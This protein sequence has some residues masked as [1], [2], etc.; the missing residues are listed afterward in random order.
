MGGKGGRCCLE[1]TDRYVKEEFAGEIVHGE[2]MR[3]INE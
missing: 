1:L 3:E 2:E